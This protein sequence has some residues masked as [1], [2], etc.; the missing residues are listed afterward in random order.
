M[1]ARKLACCLLGFG[2]PLMAVAEGGALTFYTEQFPPY[3]MTA[4]DKEFAHKSDDVGGLCTDI[5]KA[6]MNKV[7]LPYRIKLR[8][9][10]LGMER[11]KKNPDT[12]IFCAVQTPERL[13]QFSW[14]GPLTSMN[15]AL[16]ARPDANISVSSLEEA[17]Q[18]TI[19]GYKGDAMTGYLE[20]KG[21]TMSVVPD[22]ISNPKR[23]QQGIV[24]LWITDTLAGPLKASQNSGL[25]SLRKVFDVDS[26]PVYLA[27]NPQTP[28]DT[29]KALQA[30][31]DE[32]KA[33]GSVARL[34]KQY[35]PS[36]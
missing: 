35:V 29:V 2:L 11:V 10:S 36:P 3:N 15:W 28:A 32:L 6:V 14:V 8:N 12:G 30:A 31:L 19:G 17:K 7:A 9:W 18:Y 23:L 20:K 1:I 33:D 4:N 16:F 22:D 34:E 24:D 5:V 25:K 13:P 26:T 21:M 27:L